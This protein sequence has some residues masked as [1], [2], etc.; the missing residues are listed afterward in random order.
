VTPPS[1]V[2]RWLKFNAVGGIGIAVQTGA[3]WLLMNAAHLEYRA[4]DAMAVEMAVLH[5]FV[6]HEHWTWRDRTANHGG[7]HRGWAGRLLRFNLSNGVISI[8]VNVSAIW[9]LAGYFGWPKLVANFAG[10]AAGAV[11]NYL[12]SDRFVFSSAIL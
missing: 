12:A 9:L 10:I 1:W 7:I 5:N 6:W 8:V 11:A 4:A 3:L 2:V